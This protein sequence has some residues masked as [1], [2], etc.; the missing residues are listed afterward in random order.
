MTRLPLTQLEHA[1]GK[2]RRVLIIFPHRT[3]DHLATLDCAAGA[4][5]LRRALEGMG[6]R[7]DIASPGF[8]AHPRMR[9]LPD[10][11][12][13]Q[14]TIP[15]LR[16]LLISVPLD[17]PHEATL[18]HDV[19]DREIHIAITP[20]TGTVADNQVRIR[21]SSCA[22]DT[23]IVLGAP[24]PHA[25]DHAAAHIQTLL[26]EALVITI[27]YRA[28]NDVFGAINIIDYAAS[29]VSEIIYSIL[30]TLLPKELEHADVSTMLFAGLAAATRSFR[31]DHVKPHSLDTA[32]RL[33]A[34]G[35]DRERVMQ[36]L[37]RNRTVASLKLWGRAL[38]T[39]QHHASLGLVST[40]L[41][42]HDF[43]ATGG[44]PDDVPDIIHELL[45]ASGE[46]DKALVLYEDANGSIAGLLYSRRIA[47]NLLLYP[48]APHAT[49]A[50]ALVRFSYANSTLDAVR[51]T[52]IEQVRQALT[53]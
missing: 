35:A 16:Q 9:I 24:G 20:G 5:T 30:T 10:I 19:R 37:F 41:T 49:N 11:A 18:A 22:Y 25:F 13:I 50:H 39:M 31:A 47:P 26:D 15:A 2:S 43:R 51:H 23:V 34:H 52:L 8:V 4:L 17:E 38:M 48:D 7:A 3:D 42:L 14:P 53:R 44:T 36:H 21:Q 27:D 32:S 1:L 6:K 45:T 40:V 12:V 29:A 33:T 46:A 28:H